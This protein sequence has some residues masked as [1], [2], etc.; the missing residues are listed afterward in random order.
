ME[1]KFIP[2]KGKKPSKR[3]C[4]HKAT[5][6]SYGWCSPL[7]PDYIKYTPSK[8]EAEKTDLLQFEKHL[9]KEGLVVL[10]KRPFCLQVPTTIDLVSLCIS[11]FVQ[12]TDYAYKYLDTI[13]VNPPHVVVLFERLERN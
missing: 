1:Q 8:K 12:G 7:C 11:F 6:P 13:V 10:A 5:C 3:K 9:S 4:Q 2:V